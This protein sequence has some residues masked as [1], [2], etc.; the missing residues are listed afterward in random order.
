MEHLEDP[1]D[2]LDPREV[3]QGRAPAVEQRGAEEGDGG[4]LGRLDV[5]R[6]VQ[7]AAAHDPQMLGAGV[8]EGH[9]LGVEALADPGEGLEAEVLLAL[10]DPGDG[11]LAGTEGAS[12]LGLGEALVPPSVADEGADP[13]EVAVRDRHSR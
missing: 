4:V 5:D 8:T 6:A 9:E 13:L 11:A 7:L 1:V 10:L 3:A 12:Q 2:L